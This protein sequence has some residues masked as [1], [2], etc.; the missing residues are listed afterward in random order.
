MRLQ[1]SFKPFR[2]LLA[3]ACALLSVSA[4]QAA[5]VNFSVDLNVA[6][7]AG[8]GNGPFS[9]DFQL[10]Q[11]AGAVIN[12]VTLGNFSFVGGT[13]TGSATLTGGATGDLGSTV[14]LTD[15]ANPFNEFFQG[16]SAGTTD[17]LFDGSITTN[18]DP[19]TPDAFSMAVLDGSLFNIP[20]TGL[21]DSLLLVNI[22]AVNLSSADFQ[23]FTSTSPDSG[24]TVTATITPEPGT[25]GM[26][27]I[28]GLM[29]LGCGARART[30]GLLKNF[31]C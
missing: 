29:A 13:P 3:C 15:S 30:A 6:S 21:G 5:T 27:L 25:V 14:S 2:P 8:N 12:A 4:I 20:T 22:A 10:N 28:A 9:L 19:T 31:R 24:V 23:T 16:F 7:L 17:I 11:G 26:A 18:V 1:V